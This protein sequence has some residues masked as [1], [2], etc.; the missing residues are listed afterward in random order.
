MRAARKDLFGADIAVEMSPVRG[1]VERIQIMIVRAG[2]A[3]GWLAVWTV[4]T[5]MAREGYVETRDGRVFEGHLRFESNVV[6]V[7]NAER[8][9]RVEVALTNL[10]GLTFLS[11]TEMELPISAGAL[12]ETGELPRPWVHDDVGSVRR[13]G[14]AEFRRGA[15]RV[16]SAGTNTVGTADAYHWVFQPMA[17][18]GEVVA[19]ISKVQLTDPWARAGLMMRE[20]LDAGSRNVFVS[21]SAA[22]GGVFQWRE[23]FNGETEVSMDRSSSV[24]MWVK[25]KRDGDVF[26]ALKSRNGMQWTL[27]DRVTMRMS[28]DYYAGLAVVSVRGDRLNESVFEYVEAGASLRNRWFKPQVE[29]L[30][31]SSRVGYL[32]AMDDSTIYFEN[33]LGREVLSRS[34]VVNIRFQPVPSR[35]SAPLNQPRTGVLLAGGEFV[36]GDCRGIDHGRVTVSSVPLGLVQYDVNSEVLA[37]VLRKRVASDGYSYE[38]KLN[39]GSSWR[40]RELEIER[41]GVVI[42]EPTLGRKFIPLHEIAEFRRRS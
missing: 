38:V 11:S 14:D 8:M 32:T 1:I 28:K 17:D 3:L 30:S 23:S 13:A 40:G 33:A 6:V 26:T 36:E 37:V 24:P 19:R 22:R 20:S 25:I 10:A 39:D 21:V 5:T 42:R 2:L 34:S 15:F 35:H 31:G 27:V 12:V 4:A 16:R 41:L 9:L 29:L 7:A 18:R